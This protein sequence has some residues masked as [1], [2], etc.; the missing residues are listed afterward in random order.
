MVV[1][2]QIT[3][4]RPLSRSLKVA[5]WS[6]IPLVTHSTH[7]PISYSSRDKRRKLQIFPTLVYLSS[8]QGILIGILLRV[9]KNYTDVPT[10]PR[11]NVLSLTHN[12]GIGWTDG[13]TDGGNCKAI[14]RSAFVACWRAMK[15]RSTLT[16]MMSLYCI[17]EECG[18][19]NITRLLITH[20]HG[21]VRML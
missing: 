17:Q 1:L 4:I 21:S 9:Q 8:R 14:L 6:I 18:C 16:S 19:S 12:S 2:G 10:S 5:H 3:E 13:R 15:N 11:W 20:S 7:G